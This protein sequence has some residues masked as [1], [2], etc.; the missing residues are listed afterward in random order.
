[1]RKTVDKIYFQWK[2]ELAKYFNF[3]FLWI[4]NLVQ[5]CDKFYIQILAF[6]VNGDAQGFSFLSLLFSS[7]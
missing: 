2:A 3:H 7:S 6:K 5:N 4:T 1:M